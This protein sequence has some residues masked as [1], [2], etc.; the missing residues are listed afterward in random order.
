MNQTYPVLLDFAVSGTGT[1]LVA[2]HVPGENRRSW[3]RLRLESHFRVIH[4]DLPRPAAHDVLT[5]ADD[6]HAVVEA[7]APGHRPRLVGQSI[8]AVV[9]AAYAAAHP[10]GEVANLDQLLELSVVDFRR[11]VARSTSTPAWLVALDIDGTLLREDGSVS[12]AVLTQVHRLDAAG[13]HVV[14][15]TGRSAATTV[16]LLDRLGITPQFLVCA[17]GAVTLH[18]DLDVPGGYRR[19][20]V[21]SFDPADVLRSIRAHLPDARFAAE[22]N[23]GRYRLTEPFPF[24]TTGFDDEPVQ[25][26][27]E[28]L[29]GHPATRVVAFAPGHDMTDFLSVVGKM[30]LRRVSFAVGCTPWLDL[31]A[32]GVN[33]ARAAEGVR[34]E[35]GVPRERVLAVGDGHNDLELLAWAAERG[36]GVAMGQSPA[37]LIAAAGELTGTVHEDGLAQVLATL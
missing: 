1:L 4:V 23:H 2:L 27:F 32:E 11:W 29:L 15:T 37:E 6:L 5:L 19:G 25:V 17:N 35:L 28:D 3:D 33:K 18:R 21:E 34:A 9:A 14:L 13:H 31:A 10:A 20:R 22:D 26:A 36:R 7:V 24:G 8:G 30:S 12:D 16:P